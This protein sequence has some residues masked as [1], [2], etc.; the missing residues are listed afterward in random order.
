MEDLLALYCVSIVGCLDMLSSI[1]GCL[2]CLDVDVVVF[3]EFKGALLIAI[4]VSACVRVI[5]W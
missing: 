5:F 2:P 4:G 1:D 3:G